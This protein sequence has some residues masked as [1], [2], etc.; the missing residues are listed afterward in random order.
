M[1]PTIRTD[2]LIA[3]QQIDPSKLQEGD[4]ITFYSRDP[5]L[6]G[7]VNTHRI[8]SIEEE[9]G[10]YLFTTRGDANNVDDHYTTLEEDLIGKVV[11]ISYPLGKLTR[12]I[13]NPLIFIPIVLIPLAVL[14]LI[15]LRNTISLARR[16]AKEEEEQAVREAVE[17]LRRKRAEAQNARSQ[18]EA[19][20][21]AACAE[22]QN[23]RPQAE[24][25]QNAACAEAHNSRP[26]DAASQNM[27][28]A[29]NA[30]L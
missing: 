14:L 21:N 11:F 1:E 19:V 18:A 27:A 2:A 7:A 9:N 16:I 13:S 17:A 28:A 30:D 26:G 5:S 10:Q 15:N 23:A 3:V 29:E 24:A 8:V 22:E 20:Q 12:L 25:V 4:I 6:D